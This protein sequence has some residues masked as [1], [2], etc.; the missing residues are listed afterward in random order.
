MWWHHPLQL[1]LV[2]LFHSATG[3]NTALA[4]GQL[5]LCSG[6]QWWW[7]VVACGL[8]EVEVRI[9]VHMKPALTLEQ[10]ALCG[11]NLQW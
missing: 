11:G 10:L 7:Y 3:A 8:V 9:Y 2:V 1:A 5:A 4:P 6:G